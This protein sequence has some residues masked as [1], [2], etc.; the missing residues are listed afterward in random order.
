MPSQFLLYT[1]QHVKDN[2][3]NTIFLRNREYILNFFLPG[4]KVN[5]ISNL[6]DTICLT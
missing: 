4:L 1:L 6:L 2:S 5:N 3:R